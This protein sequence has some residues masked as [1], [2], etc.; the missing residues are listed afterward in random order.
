MDKFYSKE[1]SLKEHCV[2]RLMETNWYST[3]NLKDRFDFF[4]AVQRIYSVVKEMGLGLDV[5][6]TNPPTIRDGGK[7]GSMQL[8]SYDKGGDDNGS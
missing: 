7:H 6:L 8:K 2:H 3:F 5:D 4:K 1:R